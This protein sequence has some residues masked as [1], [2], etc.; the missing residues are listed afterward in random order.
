[1]PKSDLTQAFLPCRRKLRR[2]FSRFSNPLPALQLLAFFSS[3]LCVPCSHATHAHLQLIWPA[4]NGSLAIASQFFGLACCDIY[5]L[6]SGLSLA[7]HYVPAV[8]HRVF[9]YNKHVPV[10]K[11]INLKGL[12]I[13]NGFTNPAIQ[14][15]AYAD[16]GLQHNLIGKSVHDG[17]KAVRPV[18][19]HVQL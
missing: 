6:T 11:R 4:S 18:C 12:A 2:W 13:G 15:G 3:Y 19:V 9:S 10:Q 16:F 7:G 1:M 5:I 17:I 14:Y 8:A